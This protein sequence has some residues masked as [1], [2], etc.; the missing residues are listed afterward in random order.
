[1]NIFKLAS[2]N[3]KLRK[4]ANT[5]ESKYN[6]A[7][8]ELLKLYRNKSNISD[9]RYQYKKSATKLREKIKTLKREKAILKAELGDVREKL[10]IQEVKNIKLIN[11]LK[12]YQNQN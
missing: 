7:N 6:A 10:E 12:K 4:R 5:F 8:E 9:E 1:M 3:I 11:Q 2:E